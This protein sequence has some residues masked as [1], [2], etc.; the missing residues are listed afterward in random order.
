MSD[1]RFVGALGLS[2][3]PHVFDVEHDEL[4]AT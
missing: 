1:G 4:A 2:V 3:T